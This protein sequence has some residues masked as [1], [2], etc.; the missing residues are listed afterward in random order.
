MSQDGYTATEALAALAIIGMAIGGIGFGMQVIGQTER[1]VNDAVVQSA[2]ARLANYRLDGLVRVAGPFRSDG[3]GG[4]EGRADGF[5]F[6]CGVGR[7]GVE[8]TPGALTV[9]DAQGK[10]SALQLAAMHA[11]KFS[12]VGSLGVSDTWPPPALPPPAPAWQTLRAIRLSD[13]STGNATPLL[14]TRVWRDQSPT[15]EYDT[16]IQDCRRAP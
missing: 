3:A 8:A 7:C 2:A 6:D 15:C 14:V 5:S 4:F 9:T 12:Y 11:P 10:V 1:R 13:V 16:I